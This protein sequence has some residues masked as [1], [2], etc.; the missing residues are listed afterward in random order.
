MAENGGSDPAPVMA[1]SQNPPVLMASR[2][3]GTAGSH[4]EG[5][6]FSQLSSSLQRGRQ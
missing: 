4:S 6:C 2:A 1:P 3:V 5:S